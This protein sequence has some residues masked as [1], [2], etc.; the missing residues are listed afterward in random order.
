VLGLID[1]A[2]GSD[3]PGIEMALALGLRASG[4]RGGR[5]GPVTDTARG[6]GTPLP[7]AVSTLEG[8]SEGPRSVL[9]S[10]Q[11]GAV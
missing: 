2:K 9:W 3:V 4:R 8:P 7:P 10:T 1:T 6:A 11:A 5:A